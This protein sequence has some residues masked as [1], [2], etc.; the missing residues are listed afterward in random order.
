M[1]KKN[2]SW[3]RNLETVR[4]KNQKPLNWKQWKRKKL[5][6]ENEKNWKI[7][8]KLAKAKENEKI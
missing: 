8:G 1:Q 3:S 7:G 6:R 2:P 5:S 4:K